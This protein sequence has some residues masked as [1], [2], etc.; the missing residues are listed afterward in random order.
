MTFVSTGRSLHSSKARRLRPRRVSAFEWR[1]QHLHSFLVLGIPLLK[2]VG[3]TLERAH[4]EREFFVK[5]LSFTSSD[6]VATLV[7]TLTHGKLESGLILPPWLPNRRII[8]W[9]RLPRPVGPAAP[10]R[11]ARCTHR[12]AAIARKAI[13]TTQRPPETRQMMSRVQM[14]RQRPAKTKSL[15]R[16]VGGVLTAHG[17]L[18]PRSLRERVI[19]GPDSSLIAWPQIVGRQPR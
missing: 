19:R 13:R 16:C 6:A 5:R 7:P 9:Q 10:R 14:V 11:G 4:P 12:I 2:V 3:A 8:G 18:F 15:R 17:A 1:Q